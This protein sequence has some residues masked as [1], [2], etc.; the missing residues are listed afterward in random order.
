MRRDR[1]RVEREVPHVRLPSNLYVCTAVFVPA[2]D[3]HTHVTYTHKTGKTV[4]N[5]GAVLQ[6]RSSVS[7]PPEPGSEQS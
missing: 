7:V 6:S 4:Q 5:I 2:C 1:N 3:A